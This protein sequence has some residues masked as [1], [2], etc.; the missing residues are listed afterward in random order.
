MYTCM[1]EHT[2]HTVCTEAREWC[3]LSSS[4][5]TGLFPGDNLSRDARLELLAYATN[6]QAPVTLLSLA[7]SVLSL[8]V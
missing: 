7:A 3:V 5:F 2:H 1:C 8:Q 6:Q 4:S